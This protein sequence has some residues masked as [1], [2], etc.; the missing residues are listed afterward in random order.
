MFSIAIVHQAALGDTVLL[1]PL[2]RA[3][4]LRYPG[5]TMTL[6]SRPAFGRMFVGLGLIDAFA[7]AD[8][9]DHT[10]WFAPPEIATIPGTLSRPNSEPGWAQVDLLLCAVAAEASPWANN[11]RLARGNHKPGS[12]HFFQPRPP[13]DYPGHVTAWHR[14]QL[15]GLSLPEPPLPPPRINPDGGVLIHPG[16]GSD[17]K[18]WPLDRFV[19]LAR[20]FKSRGL[21]PTFLLGEAE[22][23]CGGCY[24]EMRNEFPHCEDLDLCELAQRI[25]CAGLYVGNDAGVTHL[26]AALGIPTVVLFGPSD[27][28]Q[29][30]PVGPRVTVVRASPRSERSMAALGEGVV[31][32]AALAE[33]GR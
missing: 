19:G 13:R 25:S 29:W 2:F 21:V 22:L 6:V 18:C 33:L 32:E 17:A 7:S 23:E 28:V 9:R 26:A 8:D 24:R 16:S 31:W 3:L 10:L 12:L 1:A 4:R 5:C 27:D 30:G 15:G 20:R 14:A 11:A